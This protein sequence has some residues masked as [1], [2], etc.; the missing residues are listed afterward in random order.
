MFGAVIFRRTLADVK[1]QGS[2]WDTS[3]PLYGQLGAVPHLYNLTWTFPSGAKVAFGHLEHETTVLDWQGAQIPLIAFDELTHF[4][5]SQFWY[6]L[7]R[8]R[9]T[10]GIRPYVRAT[11]NPDSESWVADLISWWISPDT[12]LVIPERAGILRWFARVGDNLIWADSP[13]ELRAAHPSSQPKSLTFVP[14]T[15]SD[16]KI[17]MAADADYQ[18]NLMAL[19]AVDRGRLLDGN[20]KVRHGETFFDEARMLVDGQPVPLPT[21]CDSVFAVIDCAAKTGKE[22]DGTAVVYCARSSHVGHPLTIL[23]YDIV[24][25]DADLLEAWLPIVFQNLEILAA[26]CRARMG[27]VGVWIEDQSSGIVLL[28]QAERKNLVVH[29][30]ESKLTSVGKD[31]RAMSVSGY[32]QRGMVKIS[33]PA[34]EKVVT[35]KGVTRNH[36]LSQIAGF[37]IGDKNAGTRPDDLLDAIVYAI[38]VALGNE[39]G[40]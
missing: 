25:I 10:S 17:L 31:Q 12:G 9:T 3:L 29:P 14:A 5:A 19:N 2:L 24:Q 4:T 15:L 20:W 1:K 35:F 28:K 11:C 16:N 36:L 34:Y 26:A 23:D 33:T 22:H 18:A 40:F 13:E 7:S 8:N 27:S 39:E 37:G 38:A 32:Y 6:L 21:L 30:I